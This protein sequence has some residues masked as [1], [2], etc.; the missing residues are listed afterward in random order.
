MPVNDAGRKAV[1]N[2]WNYDGNIVLIELT[3]A[4]IATQRLARA[5]AN[6]ISTLGGGPA[7]EFTAY[8][9]EFDAI[10]DTKAAPR[11]GVRLSNVTQQVWALVKNLTTPPRVNIYRVI[12]SAVDTVQDQYLGLDVKAVRGTM[13]TLEAEFGHENYAVEPCPAARIVPSYCPWMR[14]VG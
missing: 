14:L 1:L 13:L 3:H 5:P 10:T 12:E 4:G 7:L 6:V 8:P 2:A 9:F 11:G